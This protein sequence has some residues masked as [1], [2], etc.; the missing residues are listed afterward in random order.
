MKQ[1]SIK[2]SLVL[3][4]SLLILSSL[5]PL[6][7][8]EINH[9]EPAPGDSFGW[10]LGISGDTA[11]VGAFKN[12]E[13]GAVYV[14]DANTGEVRHKLVSD[15]IE[16]DDYFGFWS[17]ISGNHI[18]VSAA[19]K[20]LEGKQMAGAVYLFDAVTGQQ[21]YKLTA[22]DAEQNDCFG[23]T[24]NI[25]GNQ[26][27]VGSIFSNTKGAAYLFNATTGQQ[28]HKLTASDGQSGDAFGTAAV[29][30]GNTALVGASNHN[31]TGAAYLF[32][33][34]TGVQSYKL[35]ASDAA[36]GDNFGWSGA[37]DGNTAIV[38]ADKKVIDGHAQAGAAYI[39][40][41]ATGQQLHRLVADDAAEND[42]FG[43]AVDVSGQTAIVGAAHK[44]VDGKFGAGAAYLFDTATGDQMVKLTASNGDVLD[45]FGSCVSIEND[46]FAV[47]PYGPDGGSSVYLGSVSSMTTLDSGNTKK[48]ISGISFESKRDW[49]IGRHTSGNAVVL[50][51]GDSAS[52]LE[53]DKSVSIGMNAGSNN[54]T[55]EIS[56]TLAA[57]EVYIGST[58]GN[59]GNLLQ[60]NSEADYTLLAAIYLTEGN[61]LAFE[62][63]WTDENQLFDFLGLTDLYA[64][65]GAGGWVAMTESNYEQWLL[66]TKT[67]TDGMLVRIN[68]QP[69]PEP[70]CYAGLAGL[71]TLLFRVRK[72]NQA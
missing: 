21:T 47:T 49:I 11:I 52:I 65:N 59:S 66:I 16:E 69:I 17:A 48:T 12:G 63:N 22:D 28:T 60:L 15:D 1:P 13:G 33:A 27:I 24:S 7:A 5:S 14:F 57:H 46:N 62:Q 53:T 41:A 72:R 45:R 10:S 18:V 9:P 56:G 4:P 6:S 20:T 19:S 29:I 61:A 51:A 3:L 26:V 68:L 34:T 30:N 58:G 8:M 36:A 32:D 70:A 39:Y 40:N 43:Y 25:W 23:W 50:G 38:G 64:Y 54:N 44:N 42:Q 31:G 35:A 2:R 71:I 67:A 37:L 55:L